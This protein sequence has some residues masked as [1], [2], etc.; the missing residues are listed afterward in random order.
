VNKHMRIRLWIVLLLGFGLTGCAVTP[1]SNEPATAVLPGKDFSS[2]RENP[3][4]EGNPAIVALLNS[5]DV[6]EQ[7]GRLDQAGAALE[8]ALRLEP[9]NAMLWHRLARVRL[10]Q[11]QWQTAVDMAVKS[12]SLAVG[13]A[14]LQ[15]WNW[16]LIAEA[17]E[18]Q[19]DAQGA[20]AARARIN[21][22]KASP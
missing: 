15:A 10:K 3:A 13:N 2:G 18:Q 8:R 17:K 16:A 21:G 6:K 12:N 14:D 9:R 11:G 4:P 20:Q 1:E 5:A 19:G 22:A 7:A